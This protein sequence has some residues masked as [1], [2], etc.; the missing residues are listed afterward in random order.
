MASVNT[1][2]LPDPIN[3][4]SIMKPEQLKEIRMLEHKDAIYLSCCC[5]VA[6]PHHSPF[7][8]LQLKLFHFSVVCLSFCVCF[9]FRRRI[10]VTEGCFWAVE[11]VIFPPLSLCLSISLSPL[12]GDDER[13][14]WHAA[15]LVS[16]PASLLS[17][18]LHL[19][20]SDAIRLR[21]RANRTA[22]AAREVTGCKTR[23]IRNV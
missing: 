4:P 23:P 9:Y 21:S 10:A 11:L 2:S 17:D 15:N 5:R 18:H 19:L 7:I 13:N 1:L 6:T 16:A 22:V 14:R 12:N 3:L 8:D 20:A